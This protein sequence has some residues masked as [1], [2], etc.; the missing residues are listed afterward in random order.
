MFDI[1]SINLNILFIDLSRFHWRRVN[2]DVKGISKTSSAHPTLI[3]LCRNSLPLRVVFSSLVGPRGQVDVLINLRVPASLQTFRW[4]YSDF[5]KEINIRAALL[6][7]FFRLVCLVEVSPTAV[8]LPVAWVGFIIL[9][10]CITQ[11]LCS[12]ACFRWSYTKYKRRFFPLGFLLGK[13][14]VTGTYLCNY[15][16]LFNFAI[17][18]ITANASTSII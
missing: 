7:W 11:P 17:K 4:I 14:E 8:T 12:M 18:P 1:L 5:K 6:S 9:C 16:S 2:P 3:F 15:V 13:Y 10:R